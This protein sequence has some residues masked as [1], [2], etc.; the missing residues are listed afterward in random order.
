VRGLLTIIQVDGAVSSEEL[1]AAPH[2]EDLQSWLGGGFI[3]LVPYFTRYQ[4][5][6]CL[7]FCDE[8]GKHKGMPINQRATALWY[9]LEPRFMGMDIL[10][11]PI[12]IVS[13][14]EQL[15]REL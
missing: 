12:V 5:K 13:G 4:G 1:A 15:M 2:L 8:D 11:G 10:V 7:A 14:D 6:P 3:E 9:E